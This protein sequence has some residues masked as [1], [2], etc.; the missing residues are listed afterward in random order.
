M[1][2]LGDTLFVL[3][4]V[5]PDLPP[6]LP[7]SAGFV[8][9]SPPFRVAVEACRA[10]ARTKA[11]VL[12]CGETGTGK[13]V[14]AGLLHRESGR[15]GKLVPVNCAAIAAGVFEAQMFGYRRGAFTGAATDFSGHVRAARGGTLFLDEIGELEPEVQAK[16]LR[17][18]DSGEAAAVGEAEPVRV[19]VR[20]VAA[21]NRDL[22]TAI[23]EGRFRKDLHARIARWTV[24]LPPLRE[25][26]EDALLLCSRTLAP[27]GIRL[28]ADAAEAVLVHDWPYNAREVLSACEELA[29]RS[30]GPAP[31]GLAALPEAVTSR[32]RAARAGAAA[33]D[34][35]EPAAA[36][37]TRDELARLLGETGGNVS[38]IARRLGKHRAQIYRWLARHGLKERDPCA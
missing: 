19:D 16:L 9:V 38:E 17:F 5:P 33:G 15:P 27:C 36:A 20:V 22:A 13:E 6:P 32:L 10:A 14:L 18:L 37:P 26:P 7:E 1:I 29:I 2:R 30:A 24:R 11:T 21:T 23:A 8:A 28:D 3:R 34:A 4:V 31:V 35:G 12:L 25:R